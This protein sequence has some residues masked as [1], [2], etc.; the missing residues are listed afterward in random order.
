MEGRIPL[1]WQVSNYNVPSPWI[2]QRTVFF[3]AANLSLDNHYKNL[4]IN[5][6]D[7]LLHQTENTSELLQKDSQS[8]VHFPGGWVTA[9]PNENN[10]GHIFIS[11]A[12]VA[13]VW[14]QSYRRTKINFHSF[15]LNGW[16]VKLLTLTIGVCT[17]SSNYVAKHSRK[18]ALTKAYRQLVII[19]FLGGW[20]MYLQ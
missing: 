15:S 6:T 12:L 7:S 3:E 17:G 16:D 8:W 13:C 5:E 18:E 14:F 10:D 20:H 19:S 1:C 11:K 2:R 9:T 4:T